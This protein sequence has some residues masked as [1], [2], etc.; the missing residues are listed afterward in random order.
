VGGTVERI[1]AARV[2]CCPNDEHNCDEERQIQPDAHRSFPVIDPIIAMLE[3][4]CR[5]WQKYNDSSKKI[6]E[7]PKKRAL[8]P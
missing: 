5:R 1:G 3:V 6:A 7:T 2:R 8:V 4:Y